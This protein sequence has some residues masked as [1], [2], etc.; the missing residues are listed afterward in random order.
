[1]LTGDLVEA[2]RHAAN[3]RHLGP[4]ETVTV[5]VMGPAPAGPVKVAW[6]ET[7]K[8]PAGSGAHRVRHKPHVSVAGRARVEMK[9][10]QSIDSISPLK[11]DR[12]PDCL[13]GC[14]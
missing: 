14:L 4:G 9:P 13:R 3:M 11:S 5:I 6:R 8:P 10:R 1:M 12:P 7:S 2:L